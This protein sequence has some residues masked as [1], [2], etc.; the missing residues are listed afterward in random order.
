VVELSQ[1]ID[2]DQETRAWG[3]IGCITPSGI[4]YLTTRGGPITGPELLALQGI[5]TGK[6]SL[7]YESS[8]QL[9]DFAG[10]AMT[11][12]VVC[13]A[14]LAAFG[15]GFKILRPGP[16]A[17]DIPSARRDILF[18]EL[19]DDGT[20]QPRTDRDLPV[21]PT[22]LSEFREIQNLAGKTM[23]L[24][25][26]E[27]R[28]GCSHG[29]LQRCLSCGHTTCTTC[30]Q[31]PLHKYE[32]IPQ[33]VLRQRQNPSDFEKQITDWLPLQL[34][35]Q[36]FDIPAF[37]Y[38]TNV[39][40]KVT[41]KKVKKAIEAA[42]EHPVHLTS[43]SRTRSWK[44]T[45]E[46][47]YARLDIVF[48]RKMASLLSSS[49]ELSGFLGA[50]SVKCYLYAK[51]DPNESVDSLVRVDLTQPIARMTCNQSLYESGW[52]IRIPKPAGFTLE[53]KYLG[54]QIDS[55]EAN[56]G[57]KDKNFM[58]R[59]VTQRV[60]LTCSAGHEI[61][62]V[63]IPGVYELLPDCDA[64]CGSLHRKLG[65][66]ESG[67]GP[68]QDPIFF[69]LDPGTLCNGALDSFVFA[70]THHRLPLG[71]TRDVLA[72]VEKGWRPASSASNLL[73]C[74]VPGNWQ[75]CGRT[76]LEVPKQDGVNI[77]TSMPSSIASMK[78]DISR[79]THVY[80]TALVCSFP[81]RGDQHTQWTE[82]N[83][84]SIDLIDKPDAFRPFTQIIQ[85][86]GEECGFKNWMEIALPSTYLALC[87]TC[88]PEKPR[89]VFPTIKSKSLVKHVKERSEKP[90][91]VEDQHQ[92]FEFEEKI[93]SRPSPVLADLHCHKDGNGIL[94]LQLNVATL[95]HRAHA[96]IA[97]QAS[98][99]TPLS[100]VQWRLARDS[101][102]EQLLPFPE[103][104]PP[105]NKDGLLADYPPNWVKEEEEEGLLLKTPQRQS[106]SWMLKQES[107]EAEC[108]V[109]VE[110]EEARIPSA[111]LRLEAKV[112]C[113]R[114]IRGG[115]LADEVGYGKTATILALFDSDASDCDGTRRLP[116]TAFATADGKIDVKATLVLAPA[117]L[118]TQWHS[119]FYRFLRKGPSDEYVVLTIESEKHLKALTIR[120][121]CEADFI[122]STW[123]VFGD[124][125]LEELAYL[126][127][128]PQ[129]PK[130]SG[131]AFQQ[132]LSHALKNLGT[133][134][135]GSEACDYEDYRPTWRTLDAEKPGS[136]G[137]GLPCT[138]PDK[139][140][141]EECEEE[142]KQTL[143]DNFKVV[144]MKERAHPKIAPLLHL[145][146]FRRVVTDEFTYVQ[147]RQLSAL[148]ELVAS[149]KWVLSGTP[150]LGNFREI[151]NMAMLLGTKLSTDDNDG[152]V[153][154]SQS[155]LKEKMKDKTC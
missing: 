140:A 47:S 137:F 133:V 94:K 151:N 99:C 120:Q 141:G 51:P 21:G 84:Y 117:D 33:F 126:G 97:G 112:E 63:E 90:L 146:S 115:I 78:V 46:S 11:S 24:C 50:I 37:T 119:E 10:N 28:F 71:G 67:V 49:L 35:F 130:R 30:G 39:K 68:S 6:L 31:N 59:Q 40:V 87:Q 17:S 72:Q 108:W 42:F 148:L 26:C 75:K 147:G 76:H 15:V 55:W 69:F 85:R 7:T 3:I 19:I 118:L 123:E 101:G 102:F 25:S 65:D 91:L 54:R 113:I 86:A 44:A 77:K 52:E 105:S 100:R 95:V 143:D 134:V 116:T 110:I 124:W 48:S 142:T 121:I 34:R 128:S 145:F 70:N 22:D 131:R 138:A 57:L 27:G 125:Y 66:A 136:Q 41:Q 36:Y 79:C 1:N 104:S 58:D 129:L 60:G 88:A 82:G 13:A 155:A 29:P 8:R 139:I 38:S 152:G 2:R 114:R 98:K 81:L 150:P 135:M 111:N 96:K 20:G 64:A 122:L 107:N 23:Q 80:F 92:A 74:T 9:Q 45:Y 149:R 56:L 106:L 43:F 5:P 4:P 32:L 18:S 73:P 109:E 103:L 153:F 132:W 144:D 93:R 89:L 14:L 83:V 12:T 62:P 16:G 154:E 127:R 61:C 53:I